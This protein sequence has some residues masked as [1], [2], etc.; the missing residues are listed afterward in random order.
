MA[1]MLYGSV[2]QIKLA[3][4]RNGDSH[5]AQQKLRWRA[6]S[7]VSVYGLFKYLMKN[8]VAKQLEIKSYYLKNLFFWACEEKPQDF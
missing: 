1:A 4:D 5:S 6:E 3:G 8:E 2:F 7:M